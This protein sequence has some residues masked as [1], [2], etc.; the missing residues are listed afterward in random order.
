MALILYTPPATTPLTCASRSFDLPFSGRVEIAQAWGEN[1]AK[2]GSAV[3]DAAIVLA[4]YL[5][6]DDNRSRWHNLTS[7]ELGAGLGLSSIVAARSGFERVLATDGDE[8]VIQMAQ[9]NADAEEALQ[10]AATTRHHDARRPPTVEIAH[11]S[12][13]DT[14]ALDALLPAGTRPPDMIMASDVLYLGAAAAW[15]DFLELVASL[16][17]RRRIETRRAAAAAAAATDASGGTALPVPPQPI[18]AP[19]PVARHDGSVSTEGDPLVLL[20]HTARYADEERHFFKAARRL[21]FRAVQLPQEA[22]TPPY[23]DNGRSMMYELHWKGDRSDRNQERSPSPA[24]DA[25][26]EMQPSNRMEQRE[27]QSMKLGS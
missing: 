1:G 13:N 6:D 16:C 20:S 19:P 5:D 2:T 23:R 4:H 25:A 24:P 9:R 18:W 12:W 26:T 15:T 11:L 27:A 3:W 14:A 21:N 8:A 10:A 22:V 17:R 7:L